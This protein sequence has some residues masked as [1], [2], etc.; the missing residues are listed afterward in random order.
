MRRLP[1]GA[2]PPSLDRLAAFAADWLRCRH[3]PPA[4][5][6]AL[7]LVLTNRTV[8]TVGRSLKYI[9]HPWLPQCILGFGAGGGGSS[10]G[11]S[12]SRGSSGDD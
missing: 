10:S 1:A 6:R 3:S 7:P 5:R 8:L 12:S 4:S 11:G 9:A 2:A